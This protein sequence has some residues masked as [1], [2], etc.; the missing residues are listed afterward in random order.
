V[1]QRLEDDG[2]ERGDAI[3][4]VKESFDKGGG[5]GDGEEGGFYS[6]LWGTRHISAIL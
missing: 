3:D 2:G 4:G 1:K 6:M 5:K